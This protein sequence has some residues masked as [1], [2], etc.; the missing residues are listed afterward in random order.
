MKIVSHRLDGDVPRVT[1]LA[2]IFMMFNGCASREH[3]HQ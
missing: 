1:R 3:N 2:A